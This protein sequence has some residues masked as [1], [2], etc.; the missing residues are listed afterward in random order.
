MKE[1]F[2]LSELY[3]KDKRIQD[4]WRKL[5]G[6]VTTM[7][8]FG[9][10]EAIK[11]KPV[12]KQRKHT[13]VSPFTSPENLKPTYLLSPDG[14]FKWVWNLHLFYASVAISILDPLLFAF[15]DFF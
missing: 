10:T 12:I 15:G 8:L 11:N 9:P 6:L 2:I 5:T 14:R 4:L 7:R 3:G 13:Y 1:I